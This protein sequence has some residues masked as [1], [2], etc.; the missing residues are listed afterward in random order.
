MTH[1]ETF[2][3]FG[4][5]EPEDAWHPD[6]TVAEQLQNLVRRTELLTGRRLRLTGEPIDILDALRDTVRRAR[7]KRLIGREVVRADQLDEDIAHV[8]T[9]VV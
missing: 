4:D 9:R 2:L 1:D 8:F 6:D 3:L 5:T 7:R